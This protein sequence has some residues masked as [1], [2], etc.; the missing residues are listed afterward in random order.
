VVLA[1]LLARRGDP[2][3][4]LQRYEAARVARA[5]AVVLESRRV[6]RV[7]QIEHGLARA[8]RDLALRM[9]P[10]GLTRRGITRAMRFEPPP[11]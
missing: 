10:A 4:A 6:G 2:V 9:V 11:G 5:N 1:A 3:A 8:A 7:G